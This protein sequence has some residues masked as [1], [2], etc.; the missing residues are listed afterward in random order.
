MLGGG[1]AVQDQL[2]TVSQSIDFNYLRYKNAYLILPECFYYILPN[3][4]E[5]VAGQIS[6][7]PTNAIE[8]SLSLH[9]LTGF[10]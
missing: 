3:L 4:N 7:I 9:I 10:Y 8:I 2:K 1:S 5:F 6:P